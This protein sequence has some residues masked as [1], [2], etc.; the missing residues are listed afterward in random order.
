MPIWRSDRARI[1]AQE[2]T[3]FA[4]DPAGTR[5]YLGGLIASAEI[6]APTVNWLP[7]RT[8]GVDRHYGLVVEGQRSLSEIRL[9]IILQ[10]PK[11]FRYL[12]EGRKTVTNTP[13]TGINTH[14]YSPVGTESTKG[15]LSTSLVDANVQTLLSFTTEISYQDPTVG[16]TN[17]FVRLYH[18]CKIQNVELT[19]DSSN[20]LL[21]TI[22]ISAIVPTISSTR[23]T[24]VLNTIRPYF[25]SDAQVRMFGSSSTQ[26][27]TTGIMTIGSPTTYN[28][29]NNFTIN[30]E[31]NLLPK[32]YA[33]A[34]GTVYRGGGQYASDIIPG[35]R[36]ITGSIE[37]VLDDTSLSMAGG[38]LSSV[39]NTIWGHLLSVGGATNPFDMEITL[40]RTASEDLVRFQFFDCWISR[41]PHIIPEDK[42]DIPVTVEF[43][44]RKM[45]VEVVNNQSHTNMSF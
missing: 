28:R 37:T 43:G 7:Y 1:Y 42:A 29:I 14:I 36:E 4:A 2:E 33:T 21:A 17:H 18:G 10:T 19:L 16:A 3:T 22:D 27:A 30:I 32:Y 20:E 41:A 12:F 45:R 38:S 8:V 9:P 44:A 34:S 40:T 6:T 5:T 24:V 11:I 39:N 35:L 25:F 31:N 23:S 26:N 15:D 13:S